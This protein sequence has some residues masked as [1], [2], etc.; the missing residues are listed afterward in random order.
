MP[1]DSYS[2]FIASKQQLD[3]DHGFEPNDLPDWLFDY[4]RSLVEWSLRK[5]RSAIFADCGMGKTPMQLVW[6]DRVFRQTGRRVLILTPLAVGSQT[7][8]EAHKFGYDAVQSRDGS[9]TSPIV[10]T[11]YE[12]LHLFSPDD[13]SG[14]VCDE[15]SILK[16][17]AGVRRQ[18]ITDFMQAC[19]YR[20]LAT[21]TP[22]PN[23]WVELGTSSEAL[24][25]LRRVEMLAMHFTHDGGETQK[26]RLRGHAESAFWRWVASWARAVRRPSDIGGSDDKMILPPLHV[27]ETIV[28]ASKPL[29]GNLFVRPAETLEEQRRERRMTLEERCE[30]VS[31]LVDHD[32]PA[33]AWCHLNAESECLAKKIPDSVQVSGSD[34]EERK[35]EIFDGFS[36][37]SIR[38]LITKPS[39]AGFGLNWQHCAHQTFFPSHSFEQYYQAIRRS[40]RFGQK[41][42]VTI[43]LV[44]SEGEA[45]VLEN[46]KRKQQDAD[47]MFA[48]MIA[49]MNDAVAAADR[50]YSNNV[51]VPS[52]L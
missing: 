35:E 30:A 38:V 2:D 26:W 42:D 20:L 9:L 33:V 47:R 24:G 29:P 40:W 12:K 10:V 51:E 37:G 17:Y 45:G 5:G 18:E 25:Y 50:S 46:M 32:R 28:K 36:S 21:A 31:V 44:T 7:V 1:T 34:S 14:V 23:D 8:R 4:Q 3:G 48:S 49:H 11:N 16:N 52:W 43:D 41:S 22:A 15:S 19:R 39:I 6:A 27:R 13:F